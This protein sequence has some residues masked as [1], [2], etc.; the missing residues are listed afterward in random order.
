MPKVE[1]TIPVLVNVANELLANNINTLNIKRYKSGKNNG[2]L[3]AEYTLQY[4]SHDD[5]ASEPKRRQVA[6]LIQKGAKALSEGKAIELT[7]QKYSSTSW[8]H[9]LEIKGE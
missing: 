5:E 9:R 2:K 3:F 7:I 8:A 1:A 4:A 6:E